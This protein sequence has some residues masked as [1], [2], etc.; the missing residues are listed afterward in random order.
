MYQHRF[1]LIELNFKDL[2]NLGYATQNLTEPNLKG[3][4]GDGE[5]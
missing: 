2:Q 4:R 1:K 3:L 5:I